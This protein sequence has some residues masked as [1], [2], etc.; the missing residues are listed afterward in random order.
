M[1]HVIYIYTQMHPHIDKT[2]MQAHTEVAI[3]VCMHMYVHIKTPTYRHTKD[4]Y[5][6][7]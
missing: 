2:Q 5:Y 3:N 1:R 7:Y 4:Y 6:Y